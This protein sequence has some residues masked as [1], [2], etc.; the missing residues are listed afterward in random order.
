MCID[1]S[2]IYELIDIRTDF[3]KGE[4]AGGTKGMELMYDALNE[5]QLIGSHAYMTDP[6]NREIPLLIKSQSELAYA[7]Q[8][9][10]V[11]T[12]EAYPTRYED[13]LKR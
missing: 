1:L 2:F 4:I 8:C 10:W 13:L 9:G 11:L 3:A 6:M 12:S 5:A 7:W